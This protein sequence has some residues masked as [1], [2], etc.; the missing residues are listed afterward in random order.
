MTP[1]VPSLHALKCRLLILK[2]DFI[3]SANNECIHNKEVIQLRD[4]KAVENR[5]LMKTVNVKFLDTHK[6]HMRQGEIRIVNG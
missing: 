3:G 2:G 6:T 4:E 1:K 5:W